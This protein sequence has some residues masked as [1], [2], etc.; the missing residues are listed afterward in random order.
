M[1]VVSSEVDAAGKWR[2]IVLLDDGNTT[3]LKYDKP[4]TDKVVLTK[5][6]ADIAAKVILEKATS[7]KVTVTI[8]SGGAMETVEYA[9][10]PTDAVL[11]TAISESLTKLA[12]TKTAVVDVAQ[13]EVAPVAKG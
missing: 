9:A 2:V 4:Q 13:V 1:N 7:D 11:L 5:V 6:T 3:M 10:V 12:T 8:Q